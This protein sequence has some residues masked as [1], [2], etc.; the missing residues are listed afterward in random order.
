MQPIETIGAG[1]GVDC[2]WQEQGELL[3]QSV[4]RRNGYEAKPA[5]SIAPAANT[6]FTGDAKSH[7]QQLTHSTQVEE[8]TQNGRSRNFQTDHLG[9]FP[10]Y[11]T[12]RHLLGTN[13]Q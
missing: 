11:G 1:A 10:Y 5:R 13:R 12:A 9:R 4:N 7:I 3:T 2:R 6:I 8:S